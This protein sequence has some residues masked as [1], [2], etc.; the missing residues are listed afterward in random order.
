MT[1]LSGGD[2]RGAGDRDRALKLPAGWSLSTY[3]IV[4]STNAEA[5]RQAEAG[6]THGSVVWAETQ[7]AGRG[8]YHRAWTSSPGNLLCSVI[9]RPDCPAARAGQLSFVVAV[10]AAEAIE[11]VGRGLAV[12]V[13]WPNDILIRRRKCVGILLETDLLPDGRVAWVVA[14][15]GVNLTSHPDDN[16]LVS[17]T[18]L[19]VEGVPAINA[20][21]FL[22]LFLDRL[23]GLE[24]VWR[25][26]GFALVRSAWL[27]RAVGI[28]EAVTVNLGG[29]RILTGRFETLD[30]AGNLV[31]RRADGAIETVSAGDV[32][33][34]E[35]HAPNH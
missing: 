2:G 5:R 29:D 17:A 28:G 23:A 13:K 32:F 24:A 19:T 26:S 3:P 6:A 21:G 30:S 7:S 25:A 18:N 8:R 14:G 20:A 11:S 22:E 31:L 27:K 15:I 33:F 34:G 16:P 12:Q 4:D 10:A 1:S 35:R 9:L